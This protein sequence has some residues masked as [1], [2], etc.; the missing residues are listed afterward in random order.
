MREIIKKQFTHRKKGDF[1][2]LN[3]DQALMRKIVD[4]MRNHAGKL[5]PINHWHLVQKGED[6]DDLAVPDSSVADLYDRAMEEQY[7]NAEKMLDAWIGCI[8]MRALSDQEAEKNAFFI[9]KIDYIGLYDHIRKN[10]LDTYD[11]RL[12]D[13]STIAEVNLLYAGLGQ[14]SENPVYMMEVGGGYGAIAEAVMNVI[15][16][17]KYVMLDA[18]PGSILYSYEYLKSMLSDKKVGFYYLGDRFDLEQFDVYIIPAW[19]FEEWNTY[20]YD[21]CINISS[22]QEMG[23]EHVNYYLELF[24]QVLKVGGIAYIQNSRDYVFQGEWR[25]KKSWKK[26]FMYNTPAS[27]TNY[28]PAEMYLKGEGDASIW[29]QCIEAGYHYAL[30]EKQLLKDKISELEKEIAVFRMH[31]EEQ[32]K[33]RN[34]F[35]RTKN[36]ITVAVIGHFSEKQIVYALNTVFGQTYPELELIISACSEDISVPAVVDALAAHNPFNLKR[37]RINRESDDI[38]EEKYLK[39]ICGNM[40]GDSLIIL[41]NGAC[42]HGNDDLRRCVNEYGYQQFILGTSV[43]YNKADEYLMDIRKNDFTTVN[44]FMHHTLWNCGGIILPRHFVMSESFREL[45]SINRL[46][47]AILEYISEHTEYQVC[48]SESTLL[49]C[50]KTDSYS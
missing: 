44:D 18:V 3:L 30:Y 47:K 45:S 14:S 15:S 34:L 2:R 16:G 23:Q 11:Y 38:S 26:I 35:E 5:L 10:G 40:L 24:D 12:R 50:Y 13:M 43:L 29:N 4:D 46:E 27:W 20:T 41:S 48:V 9:E 32:D 25:F 17:V 42:F 6:T 22:M 8:G 31:E 7:Y 39:Y 36:M 49:K 1:E 37:V 21:C 28:Y 33:Y 19:H